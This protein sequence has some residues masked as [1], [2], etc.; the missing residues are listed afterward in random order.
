MQ[1]VVAGVSVGWVCHRPPRGANLSVHRIHNVQCRSGSSST[2][3][4]RGAFME[5]NHKRT[6]GLEF[7]NFYE[8]SR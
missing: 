4:L 2:D 6:E 5:L 7:I 3:P 1:V 8:G